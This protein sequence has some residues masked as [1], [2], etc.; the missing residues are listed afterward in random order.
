MYSFSSNQCKLSSKTYEISSKIIIIIHFVGENVLRMMGFV[1]M[2]VNFITKASF[3][4]YNPEAKS[5][6]F[7]FDIV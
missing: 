4:C 5:K 7:D 1:E 6:R 3:Y 2:M